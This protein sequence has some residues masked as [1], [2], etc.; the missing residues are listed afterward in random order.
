MPDIPPLITSMPNSQPLYAAYTPP[1]PLPSGIYTCI[2]GTTQ[3]ITIP[4]LTTNAVVSLTYIHPTAGGAA[5]YFVSSVPTANTLTVT[6]GVAAAITERI[7]YV[8]AKL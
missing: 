5:Q 2:V 7:I 6:L 1:T 8:V 4:G 3:T